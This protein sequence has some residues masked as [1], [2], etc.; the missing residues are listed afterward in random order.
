ML[1]YLSTGHLLQRRLGRVGLGVA[2][3]VLG[4]QLV[5]ATDHTPHLVR[6]GVG[7]RVRVRVRTRVR[8]RVRVRV[9]RRT[10]SVSSHT[11]VEKKMRS[12]ASTW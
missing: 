4:L 11:P 8:V 10:S 12:P 7:V 6:V 3:L 5:A 9:R 2:G 1:V